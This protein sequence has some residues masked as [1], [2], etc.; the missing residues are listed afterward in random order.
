[1]LRFLGLIGQKREIWAQLRQEM[2]VITDSWL[3]L[4][5]KSLSIIA[6]R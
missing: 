4:A 6:S 1:M 2:E 3:T 5:L